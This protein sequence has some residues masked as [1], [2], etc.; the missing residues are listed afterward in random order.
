MLLQIRNIWPRSLSRQLAVA[1]IS[2]LVITILGFAIHSASLQSNQKFETNQK[3]LEIFGKNIAALAEKF[4][5]H[6]QQDQLEAKLFQLISYPQVSAIYV[7]DNNNQS[8]LSIR[9][10]DD[11][12]VVSETVP[13]KKSL[14]KVKD[15]NFKYK[16]EYAEFWFP[17]Q[18]NQDNEQGWIYIEYD[19]KVLTLIHTEIFKKSLS[20]ALF[21]ILVS[22]FLL[23]KLLNKPLRELKRAAE[24]AEWID[25]AQGGQIDIS[26]SSLE[27]EQLLRALNRTSEKLHRQEENQKSNN[28]LLD[29][30]REIQSQFISEIDMSKVFESVIN[31]SMQLTKSE[32]GFFGEIM[33]DEND[34]P[35]MK[36]KAVSSIA[37]NNHTQEFFEKYDVKNFRFYNLNNLFGAVIQAR[38][39]VIANEASID[40][41]RGGLP[42]GHPAISTFLGLPVFSHDRVVGVI[43]LANRKEGYD[44][45]MVAYLQP[46]LST[47]GDMIEGNRNEE[48]RKIVQD[49][50]SKTNSAL[51]IILNSIADGIITLTDTGFVK[52][53]NTPAA[54][55][56]TNQTMPM[57]GGSITQYIENI[58]FENGKVLVNGK[59]IF[60]QSGN[61]KFGWRMTGRHKDGTR[62]PL[63]LSLNE[64]KQGNEK[65]YIGTIHNMEHHA[66][67]NM[68][69]EGFL[70][71]INDELRET[72]ASIR[73]SLAILSGNIADDLNENALSIV[74]N[75]YK[76]TEHLIQLFENVND[77]TKIE[78]GEIELSM[79]YLKS[80]SLVDNILSNN[81][82]ICRKFNLT[83]VVGDVIDC[84]LFCDEGR[85]LQVARNLLLNAA[86]FCNAGDVIE[87]SVKYLENNIQLS[88]VGYSSENRQEYHI[89][90]KNKFTRL[91]MNSD[92]KAV[93]NDFDL[94]LCKA[95][96]DHHDGRIGYETVANN[97]AHFYVQF[98]ADYLHETALTM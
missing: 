93:D 22:L 14:P 62:F 50:L 28:V 98:P 10:R 32:Y 94:H 25:M 30:I 69:K 2:I 12:K 89:K 86:E 40:P 92:N 24:F 46:L 35:Y 85:V 13:I 95:I 82:D 72:L 31:Y 3:Q 77:I 61:E 15:D 96:V 76:N 6:K 58:A 48:N 4:L 65:I 70:A 9:M 51:E 84:T 7:L 21:A 60:I 44:Q 16:K 54:N 71:S 55:M 59:Q 23:R 78:S 41:R 26:K 88:I 19:T 64:F 29:T 73:G 47:C 5:Q 56:F 67:T 45:G 8:I 75:A 63:E 37:I 11:G 90:N 83:L 42:S 68:L 87:I 27:V 17:F 57:I 36:I 53:V 1:N 74:G 20:V 97:G 18:L 81:Q 39:V 49:E 43:G 79:G 38:K 52:Y 34:K 80:E 33:I 91:Y 66:E